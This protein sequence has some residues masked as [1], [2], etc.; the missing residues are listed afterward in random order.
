MM[1]KLNG[2]TNERSIPLV[3]SL[4][5]GG[6]HSPESVRLSAVEDRRGGTESTMPNGDPPLLML[7]GTRDDEVTWRMEKDEEIVWSD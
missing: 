2:E 4:H 7:W 5:P 3:H 1:M 6:N